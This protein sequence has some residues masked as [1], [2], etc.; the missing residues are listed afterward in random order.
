MPFHEVRLKQ[1]GLV[2][3]IVLLSKIRKTVSFFLKIVIFTALK[4]LMIILENNLVFV[5]YN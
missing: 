4:L 1:Y 5:R 3:T 2:I